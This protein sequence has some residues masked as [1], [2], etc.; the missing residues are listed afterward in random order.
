MK[1][2]RI[3]A[4]LF[5]FGITTPAFADVPNFTAT[6][7]DGTKVTSNQKGEV[8]I[9]DQ[10]AK[11][12]A[13]SSS[14]WQAHASNI[15]I[16]IGRDGAQVFVSV[17]PSGDVCEVTSSHAAGNADRSIGGVPLTDQQACLNAVSRK[18]NNKVV[19]VLDATSSEANNSVTIGVGPD[20]SKWQCLVKGG[21]VADV[22]SMTDEGGL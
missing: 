12:N 6:C 7:P 8:R 20:K 15:T 17:N 11:L 21:E 1:S 5:V 13:L 3:A 22:M 9:N 4:G 14:A 2:M 18:T 16:D 10:D 19:A